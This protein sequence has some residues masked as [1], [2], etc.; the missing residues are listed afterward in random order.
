[1]SMILL[2]SQQ[3]VVFTDRD[4]H[5]SLFTTVNISALDFSNLPSDQQLVFDFQSG[6]SVSS[7]NLLSLKNFLHNNT[8][9]QDLIFMFS[10]RSKAAN[11]GAYLKM[12]LGSNFSVQSP[13][14]SSLARVFNFTQF[15][16]KN[17]LRINVENSTLQNIPICTPSFEKGFFYSAG[18]SFVFQEEMKMKFTVTVTGFEVDLESELFGVIIGKM[19]EFKAG[20]KIRD[21]NAKREKKNTEKET[22]GKRKQEESFQEAMR[23]PDEVYEELPEETKQKISKEMW[24][25]TAGGFAQILDARRKQEMQQKLD[26]AKEAVQKKKAQKEIKKEL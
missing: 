5:S 12:R 21:V 1:M 7:E 14:Q 19:Q 16:L 26:E 9:N 17:T 25:K 24:K 23:D 22:K 11:L 10:Q 13:T 15:D 6:A 8:L 2:L 20:I 3:T 4:I 18:Y